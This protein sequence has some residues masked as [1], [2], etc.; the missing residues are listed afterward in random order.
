MRVSCGVV[1]PF[2]VLGVCIML[3]LPGPSQRILSAATGFN[4]I[5]LAAGGGCGRAL[6]ADDVSSGTQSEG[7]SLAMVHL[8]LTCKC[9][10][11]LPSL[12]Y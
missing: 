2:R 4:P 6:Y 11:E 10:W 9:K 7:Y 8:V 3:F 1:I 12:A 5:W